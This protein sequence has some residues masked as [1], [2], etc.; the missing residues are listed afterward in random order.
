MPQRHHRVDDADEVI[1]L[2]DRLA[3]YEHS[4]LRPREAAAPAAPPSVEPPLWTPL[5]FDFPYE[6]A[7]RPRS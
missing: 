3:P 2:T 6:A 7:E 5:E 4:A 1:D